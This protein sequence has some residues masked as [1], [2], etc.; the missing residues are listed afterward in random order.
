MRWEMFLMQDQWRWP[1]NRPDW[2]KIS[3]FLEKHF[4]DDCRCSHT[5]WH[6]YKLNVPML[7][8]LIPRFISSLCVCVCVCVCVFWTASA[9]NAGKD[10]WEECILT[11]LPLKL[12]RTSSCTLGH[13][14]VS[15]F[16]LWLPSTLA[17]GSNWGI[18]YRD[19]H[20]YTSTKVYICTCC[21]HFEVCQVCGCYLAVCALFW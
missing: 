18:Y 17:K 3:N 14:R 15:K 6:F 19:L 8:N 13:C 10:N 2:S 1:N 9:I 5:H 20:M 16:M 11:L 7:Y 4:P 12:K 21:S